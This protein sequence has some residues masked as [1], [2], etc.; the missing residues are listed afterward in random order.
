MTR[1]TNENHKSE[2]IARW[3]AR[4]EFISGFTGSAGSAIVTESDAALWTD[5]R[6]FLQAEKQLGAG[7]LLMKAGTAG[8]PSKEDWLAKVA[9]KVRT[10]H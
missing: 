6:Y 10:L 7:W 8:T 2:Y 5:G 3:D 4:R 1:N 9:S